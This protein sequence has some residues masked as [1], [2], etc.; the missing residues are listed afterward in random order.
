MAVLK[1][2]LFCFG[3]R[4]LDCVDEFAFVR[5][6]ATIGGAHCLSH[7]SEED[8]LLSAIHTDPCSVKQIVTITRTLH[9]VNYRRVK[10]IEW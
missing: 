7:T 1:D 4:N 10:V 9:R 2:E 5:V 8:R 3:D 6:A